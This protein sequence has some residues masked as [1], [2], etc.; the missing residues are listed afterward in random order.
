MSLLST[1]SLS[2]RK[3]FK[4]ETKIIRTMGYSRAL[5]ERLR[6]LCEA[7]ESLGRSVS[8]SV[9]GGAENLLREPGTQAVSGLSLRLCSNRGTGQRLQGPSTRPTKSPIPGPAPACRMA[10][11]MGLSIPR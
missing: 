2:R 6:N 3:L 5:Y 8:L 4:E 9:T 1:N 10:L 11:F 7:G